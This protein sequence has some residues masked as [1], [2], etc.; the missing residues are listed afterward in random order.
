MID[1][2]AKTKPYVNS[3]LL[4][5]ALAMRLALFRAREKGIKKIIVYSDS[6]MLIGAI[7]SSTPIK[8]I[9][10]TLQD[11]KNLR[12]MF[13]TIEFRYVHRSKNCL[14]DAL[15]RGVIRDRVFVAPLC[16]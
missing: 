14:A 4:A 3:P 10:G 12:S 16:V 5:E 9:F 8:E 13:S 6:Q 1:Q 11:I 15:A 2:G 7:N